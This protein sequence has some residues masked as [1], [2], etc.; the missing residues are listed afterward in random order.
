MLPVAAASRTRFLRSAALV[1]VVIATLPFIASR[2]RAA[3]PYDIWHTARACKRKGKSGV[4]S[5]QLFFHDF[6][7]AARYN[8]AIKRRQQLLILK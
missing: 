1:L 3:I 4:L 8:E 7:P 5:S 6:Q 2:G